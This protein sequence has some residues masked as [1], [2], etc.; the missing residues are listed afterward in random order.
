M[1]ETA[2]ADTGPFVHL[3]EIGRESLLRIFDSVRIPMHVEQEI[4]RLGLTNRVIS[5]LNDRLIVEDVSNSELSALRGPLHAFRLHP[6]DLSVVA[7][8]ARTQAS[9]VL[10][11]D[12]QLRKALEHRGHR[13]VGSVGILVRARHEDLISDKDFHE[14][15][16]HLLNGSTLYLSKAFR[17][18][19][20][21]LIEQQGA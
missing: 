20:L 6:A 1:T 13:V 15:L 11:D 4:A 17:T 9:T 16:D 21:D 5:V 12:L 14:S 19:I 18:Y 8:A 3:C 7:V 10:A 2:V